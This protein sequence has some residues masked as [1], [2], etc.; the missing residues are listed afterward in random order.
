[1]KKARTVK[2]RCKVKARKIKS[3]GTKSREHR[4]GSLPKERLLLKEIV[5]ENLETFKLLARY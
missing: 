4:S 1:M 3:F 2:K 5:E